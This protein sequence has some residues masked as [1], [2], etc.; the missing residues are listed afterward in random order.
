MAAVFEASYHAKVGIANYTVVSYPA[1]HAKQFRHWSLKE[2]VQL[3][4]VAV[5]SQLRQE[6]T[7]KSFMS[8]NESVEKA[9]KEWVAC[10]V[11]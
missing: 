3:L 4:K 11:V 9:E 1:S 8:C 10:C 2:V 5:K 7:W 6:K